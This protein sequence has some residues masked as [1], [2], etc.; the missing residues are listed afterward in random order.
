MPTD[1]FKRRELIHESMT[2]MV[3]R[4]LDGRADHIF[5]EDLAQDATEEILKRINA[6]MTKSI[7][8]KKCGSYAWHEVYRFCLDDQRRLKPLKDALVQYNARA[9]QN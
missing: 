6:A 4:A 8:K 7:D 5:V 3:E 2:R 1:D 9:S